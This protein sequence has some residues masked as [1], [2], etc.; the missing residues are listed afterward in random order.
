MER[1]AIS[2]HGKTVPRPGAAGR[3]AGRLAAPQTVILYGDDDYAPYSYVENGV[4]KGMYIDILRAAADK[5]PGYRLVLQPRPG[6]GPRC[7][8][9]RPGL[10]LFP[11][12]QDGALVRAALFRHAVPRIGGA[13][14]P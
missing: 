8:G 13:V 6:N 14:L 10:G 1:H 4:F 12:T 7:T 9:E 11:R 2:N 3:V 5:M